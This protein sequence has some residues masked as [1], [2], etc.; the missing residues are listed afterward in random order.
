MTDNTRRVLNGFIELSDD[1]KQEFV[2]ELQKWSDLDFS[3]RS[4]Y[5]ER[6]QKSVDLGPLS[7]ACPCCGK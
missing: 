7:G 1:E 3:E 4:R 6:V 2:D 5:Q